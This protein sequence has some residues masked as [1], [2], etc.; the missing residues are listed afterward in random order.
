MALKLVRY[1]HCTK[2]IG[3]NH[4]SYSAMGAPNGQ[5]KTYAVSV[6]MQQLSAQSIKG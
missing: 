6:I 3:A 4:P 2:R 1:P 5:A